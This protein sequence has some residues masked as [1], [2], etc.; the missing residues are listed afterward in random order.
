MASNYINYNV[1]LVFCID[2]TMSMYRILDKV[3]ENALHFYED[4]TKAMQ[5]KGK[6]VDSLRARVVAFRDYIADE[7]P[8]LVTDFFNL[9]EQSEE[10][11][12]CI[13][14]I[15]PYG[16]GD[17]PEDALEALAYAIRSKWNKAPGAM[18]REVI[19]LWTDAEPHP[20][21]F[22]RQS[23]RYPKG[24]PKDLGELSEW[25]GAPGVPGYMDERGKRI[26]IYA[27]DAPAW[28]QILQSWNCSMMYPSEAGEGLKEHDYNEIIHAIAESISF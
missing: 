24:M 25:W 13:K 14:S 28:D 15:A 5:E 17:D 27:P 9:P 6:R 23:P 7:E 16:G 12:A 3:K 1:D 18:N 21:G 22:G 2:A 26:L 4:L 11:S 8:M 10:F 20:L 19:V